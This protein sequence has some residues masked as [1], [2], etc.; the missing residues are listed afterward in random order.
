MSAS[1]ARAEAL[2]KRGAPEAA[3]AV[4]L[5]DVFCRG[6]RRR[7]RENFHRLWA[8]DD[9]QKYQLAVDVVEGRQQWQEEILLPL[10]KEFVPEEHQRKDK[11]A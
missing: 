8:N 3:E 6:A 4:V 5:A 11:A 1:V 2:R 9:T 7:I 10:L